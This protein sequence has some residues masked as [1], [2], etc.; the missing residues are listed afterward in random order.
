MPEVAAANDFGGIRCKHKVRLVGSE[1]QGCVFSAVRRM[2]GGA[3][4]AF[5]TG[6]CGENDEVAF[7]ESSFL[8]LGSE[9]DDS[10]CSYRTER[11]SADVRNCVLG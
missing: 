6:G 10:A 2:A 7:F 8:L 11:K 1:R 5:E 3:V 9:A 4:V